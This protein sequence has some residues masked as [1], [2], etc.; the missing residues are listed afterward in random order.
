[1]PANTD[2]IFTLTPQI[3]FAKV[4]AADGSTDGTDADVKLVCTA[5]A[6]GAFVNKIVLQPRSTSGSTTTSAAAAR[7]Y[8]NNGSSVG[9]G[10][11]NVLYKEVTLPATAVDVAGT[12]ESAG[13]EIPMNIQLKASYT[14]YVGVT[15]MAANTNWDVTTISGDY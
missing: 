13:W 10:T 15:A 12:T 1:M 14:I 2:P 11:N 4:S 7:I 9:T 8:I 6:N 5:G 3:T